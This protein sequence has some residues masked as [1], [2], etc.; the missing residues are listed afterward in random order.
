MRKELPVRP[1]LE[2]LKA[3]A[4]DLF[5]SFR[6][7][8]KEAFA[9]IRESLPAAA[10]RSDERIRAMSFAL[11]DA[12]SVIAREYGFASFAEL[13][14]RVTEPPAAPPRETLRALLAPFLG[15]AVPREVE[16][17]LVGAWSDTNR[18]PISVEQPLPLL[19]IRNAVL[20]VGSVAPLNIGRPASIAAIDAA[21]S[22]A[23]ALA[24]FA[25]RN[26]T[27]ESPSAADLHPVGCV[28]R[29]LSTVKTPDRGS[30]IVVRAQAW[31]RLESIESHGGYTRATLAPFAVNHDA[32]DDFDAL[33]QKLRE[34]LS[35][36]VL[37][38]PG[39]EQL[40]QMTDRMTTPELA[41]AAIANLPCSV[42][43][44]A[45]YASEPSLAARLRRV[46][47]LLE[48]AA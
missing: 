3:Q 5:S 26:D 39:G 29:L 11:H 22:G 15:M 7:G 25:Q 45:T 23:G 20:V 34:K 44:K 37:R 10:G 40:L 38:L 27:V 16:D 13:R 33:E 28:A 1:S 42:Q 4:K 36:L 2:H 41:D 18:T 32:A 19:A 24:V 35:S 12:Q 6:R 21:K 30:W 43:E 31:A 46:V 48:D 9:R 8:E 47:A 14:E 17:A